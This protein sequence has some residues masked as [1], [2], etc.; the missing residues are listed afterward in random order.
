MVLQISTGMYFDGG[1]VWETSHRRVFHTNLLRGRADDID[2]PVGTLQFAS[3]GEAVAITA[4][5]RLPKKNRDGSDTF[6]IATGGEELLADVADVVAFGLDALVLENYDLARQL[7]GANQGGSPRQR[8]RLRRTFTPQRFVTDEE[9][10]DLVELFTQLLALQRQHFEQAMRA[11]RRVVD[12]AI[13]ADTDVTL[14]YSLYVAALE[15]LSAG[16]EVPTPAWDDYDRYRRQVID[17]AVVGLPDTRVDEIRAAVLSIDQ[18]SL[19]R[20][21]QAFV[22]EHTESS[23]YRNE[24][25]DADRPIRAVELPRAL[26][27]AY[28]TRSTS[29][30][31]MRE[32][33]PELWVIAGT[34]DTTR[35]D[36]RWVL[37]L[38]GLNRLSRHVIRRFINRA[39]TGIDVDFDWN[40]ALPGVVR[41]ELDP[42]MW[43]HGYTDFHASEGPRLFGITL[44][45][46][47]SALA[48][49]GQAADMQLPLTHLERLLAGQA[50]SAARV[51]LIA[52]YLLWHRVTPQEKHRP[53]AEK[54]IDSYID[55]L[56][57]PSTP[58]LALG[59]LLSEKHPWTTEQLDN[60]IQT[61][62]TE[63]SRRRT[64]LELPNAMDAAF[65]LTL[66]LA[67]WADKDFAGATKAVAAAVDLD[68]GN[69]SLIA[70][71]AM[72]QCGT[73]PLIDLSQYVISGSLV[74]PEIVDDQVDDGDIPGTI[75]MPFE[76][77][78]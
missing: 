13:L 16:T 41:M 21:F 31:E 52:T 53:D 18:L 66:A 70:I 78:A 24:A 1:T 36:G 8:A 6:H 65:Q 23:F 11:I 37:T 20:R 64:T 69:E 42:T 60:L 49:H 30:H 7:M 44:T 47:S 40:S 55:D 62:T 75:S 61:R 74:S 59:I 5:D 28:Q 34:A 22:I 15:S 2:L 72:V 29:L 9:I 38:E 14:A 68:P 54:I 4:V 77:R 33:S 45:M 50:H 58:A 73:F 39:P 46:L 48:G 26:D 67:R 63:L 17:A 57:N 25:K 71:E 12:A 35:V 51:P 19:R 32:L 76:S 3:R 27:F 56:D 10:T 43:L